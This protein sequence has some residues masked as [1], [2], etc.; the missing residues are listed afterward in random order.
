MAKSLNSKAYGLNIAT[1]E[2]NEVNELLVFLLPD[3][4]PT[5]HW[6]S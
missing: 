5:I 2:V 6:L 1:L 4:V 3:V